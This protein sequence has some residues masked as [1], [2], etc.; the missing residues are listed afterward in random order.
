M[1]SYDNKLKLKEILEEQFFG[2]VLETILE[3]YDDRI[4]DLKNKSKA[5]AYSDIDNQLTDFFNTEFSYEECVYFN[6]YVEAEEE[7]ELDEMYTALNHFF[8]SDCVNDFC[9]NNGY[10]A[11]DSLSINIVSS[12]EYYY[13][14]FFGVKSLIELVKDDCADY[15]INSSIAF[16][17][18]EDAKDE[19]LKSLINFTV[20][21]YLRLDENEEKKKLEQFLECE[22]IEELGSTFDLVQYIIDYDM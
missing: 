7:N 8:T 20:K 16:G 13:K 9:I 5:S 2:E 22:K 6:C 12:L 21:N 10:F 11:V 4:K 17:L 3:L 1:V 18:L 14:D 19:V 15:A